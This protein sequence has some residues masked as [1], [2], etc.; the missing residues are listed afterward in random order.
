MNRQNFFGHLALALTLVLLAGLAG[1]MRRWNNRPRP[2]PN[3]EFKAEREAYGDPRGVAVPAQGGKAEVHVR[4]RP[5]VSVEQIR[6]LAARINDRMEDEYETVD[7]LTTIE[8]GDG[9]DAERVAA[10][11]NS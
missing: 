6:L 10:E 2:I 5:G 11:Y 4:F 3:R 9:L 8:D 1:Q 7:G